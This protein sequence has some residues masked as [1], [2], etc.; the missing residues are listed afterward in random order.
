MQEDLHELEQAQSSETNVQREIS[1]TEQ[2]GVP[3]TVEE[4]TQRSTPTTALYAQ[5]L[6]SARSHLAPF[7]FP[8]VRHAICK[9]C[10][11][12][13]SCSKHLQIPAVVIVEGILPP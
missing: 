11:S 13:I 7:S 6:L 12:L 2:L 5:R 10:T 1:T 8:Q 9:N 3:E 4:N